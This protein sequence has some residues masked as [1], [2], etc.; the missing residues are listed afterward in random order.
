MQYKS[1]IFYSTNLIFYMNGFNKKTQKAVF[2]KFTELFHYEPLMLVSPGRINLIGEHTDYNEGFV[3]PAAIDKYMFFAIGKNNSQKI[4]LFAADLNEYAEFEIDNIQKSKI[5]WANFIIGMVF[6]FQKEGFDIE[7]FDCVFGSTIPVGA[8]LS[9]SAA[10]ECGIGFGLSEIFNIEID[11]MKLAFMAQKAEH[12]FA[13]LKCGI[14]DQ[15]ATLFGKQNNAMKLDC[16]TLEYKYISSN[17]T[18]FQFV[19]CDSKVKH[20]LA[21]TEYNKRREECELGVEIYKQFQP[22]TKTLR[23]INLDV[24]HKNKSAFPEI[25]FNRCKFVCEENE[26]VIEACKALENMEFIQLGELLYRSHFGL[27]HEYEVS[28]KELDFLVDTA[29]MS[30][31][32]LGARMMGGGFGG[33]TINLLRKENTEKFISIVKEKFLQQF[34]YEPE[35][36]VANI[37]DGTKILN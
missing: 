1:N 27:Q 19:L 26:R 31:Y 15:F 4:K 34:H 24:L 5:H 11:K 12:D 2:E 20:S 21:S 7:G 17:F 28:C 33:C 35:C 3:L 22:E 6:Q 18:E 8:G 16:S 37:S 32:V 10:L 9:S 36:Y 23:N 30:G 25:I 29:K 14:M 13:G